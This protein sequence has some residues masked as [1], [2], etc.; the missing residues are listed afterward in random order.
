L[1]GDPNFGEQMTVAVPL[2]LCLHQIEVADAV[3][4]I[5]V[6]PFI[7]LQQIRLTC[8]GT[9]DLRSRSTYG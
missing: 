2:R 8:D 1:C 7:L 3:L 9:V 6:F 5:V 4:T